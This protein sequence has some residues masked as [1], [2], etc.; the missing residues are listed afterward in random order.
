MKSLDIS[1]NK[2]PRLRRRA[3]VY[4]DHVLTKAFV[5]NVKQNS[6][7]FSVSRK[8]ASCQML[9]V[10]H[11]DSIQHISFSSSLTF[12]PFFRTHAGGI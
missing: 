11:D 2:R 9:P 6:Y 8:T 1:R 12:S 3:C 7:L 4:P 5:R 10:V